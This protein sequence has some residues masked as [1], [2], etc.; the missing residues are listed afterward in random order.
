MMA[1]KPPTSYD[2]PEKPKGFE[3]FDCPEKFS[4][5]TH[6]HKKKKTNGGLSF[7]NCEFGRG[8]SEFLDIEEYAETQG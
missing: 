3:C 1:T 2:K 4:A 7:R 5:S 8:G 6:T